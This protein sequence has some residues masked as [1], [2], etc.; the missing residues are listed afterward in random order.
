M[1][2]FLRGELLAA[3]PTRIVVAINGVGYEV[4]VPLSSYER[5]PKAGEEVR[6]LTHLHVTDD[7]MVLYGFMTEEERSLFRIL[8]GVSGIGPKAAIGILSGIS[9]KNFRAAVREGSATLLATVPGIGKKKAERLIVELRD[10]IG[11]VEAEEGVH[12][13]SLEE[14]V[15]SDAALALV[16][17]GFTQARAQKA[18]GAALEKLGK[19]DD[20]GT[21]IREALRAAS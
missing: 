5:L 16:S 19:A 21:L 10:K 1:I 8:I 20:V 2:T 15:I 9:P 4:L 13:P 6:I 12:R 17:L 7:A 14:A 11:A 18:V 3:H